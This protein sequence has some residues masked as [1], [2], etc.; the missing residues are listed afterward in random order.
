MVLPIANRIFF[1]E[2]CSFLHII[3]IEKCIFRYVFFIEKCMFIACN[4]DNLLIIR[5]KENCT[6]LSDEKNYSKA[7]KG[8]KS[9]EEFSDKLEETILK[10]QKSAFISTFSFL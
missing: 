1:I 8:C 7:P 10:K 9:L 3:F 4:Y 6:K 5:T 2:K